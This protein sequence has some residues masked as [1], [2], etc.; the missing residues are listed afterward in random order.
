MLHHIDWK[1][2]SVIVM[3]KMSCMTISICQCTKQS[4]YNKV[5]VNNGVFLFI[6]WIILFLLKDLLVIFSCINCTSQ[7]TILFVI[8]NGYTKW[9]ILKMELHL[10]TYVMHSSMDIAVSA[11]VDGIFY[12]VPFY[13]CAKCIV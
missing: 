11:R 1:C 5:Y 10:D 2:H 4:Y 6:L 9:T 13:L 12:L 8:F 7:F 3:Y